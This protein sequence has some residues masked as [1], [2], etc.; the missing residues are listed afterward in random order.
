MLF[1]VLCELAFIPW[2]FGLEKLSVLMKI[3][4][5]EEMPKFVVFFIKYFIPVFIFIIFVI[6]WINEFS[7]N[8]GRVKNGWTPGVTWLGRLIWIVPLLIIAVGWFKRIKTEEIY[9]LIEKQYGIRFN[10]D[11]SYTESKGAKSVTN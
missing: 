10:P 6:S 4:T 9:D 3:R 2:I 11:G 1:C 8:E 7:T 5:G